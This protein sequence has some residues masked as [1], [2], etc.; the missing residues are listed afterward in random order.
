MEWDLRLNRC[1]LAFTIYCHPVWRRRYMFPSSC[2]AGYK[3]HWRTPQTPFSPL[4]G[5][6]Q[7]SCDAFPSGLQF[8]PLAE[9]KTRHRRVGSVPQSQKML[10]QKL[11]KHL[12]SSS[13]FASWKGLCKPSCSVLNPS[14]GGSFTLSFLTCCP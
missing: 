11:M 5:A 10:C 6:M 14:P 13:K 2:G 7:R 12:E 9:G 3:L 4:R 1:R 8:M